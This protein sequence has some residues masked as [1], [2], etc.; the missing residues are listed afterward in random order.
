[1]HV[2]GISIWNFNLEKSVGKTVGWT[3]IYL[4]S[5]LAFNMQAYVDD[6]FAADNADRVLMRSYL[7]N[8]EVEVFPENDELF[9]NHVIETRSGREAR[10]NRNMLGLGSRR[11]SG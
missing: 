7:N 1:M 5:V 11:F 9:A 6:R 10:N 8:R 3:N 4:G 2:G